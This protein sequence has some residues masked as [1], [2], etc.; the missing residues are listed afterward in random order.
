ML[1]DLNNYD[2]LDLSFASNWSETKKAEL[3]VGFTEALGNY[4]A[5]KL[6]LQTDASID[7]EFKK[8]LQNTALTEEQV[9]SFYKKQIPNIE[10]K[11][12]QFALEFKREFLIN[13]YQRKLD[14]AQN[15]EEKAKWQ[16]LVLQA[17]RDNWNYVAQNLPNLVKLE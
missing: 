8:L 1:T 6:S 11:I 16:E 15:E 5:Q 3:I 9:V 14:N 7:E 10:E 17:E 2:L 13:V 12:D 4:I